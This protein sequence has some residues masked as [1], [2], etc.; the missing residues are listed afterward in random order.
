M[1]GFSKIGKVLPSPVLRNLWRQLLLCA[2][3]GL[4]AGLGAIAFF[5]LLDLGRWFFM[6][7]LIGYQPAP[8]GGESPMFTPP[9]SEL[10]RWLFLV[11]PAAGGLL[12]GVLIYSLAPEAEGHGTDAAIDAYH[13]KAGKV[14]VRVPLV[15]A[16]ASAIT[17]GSGGSGGRE[18]PIAQIGSGF[19]SML[20]TWLHLKP[21]ERRVLM[22][23][24]MGAGIGAI[25]HAPL[26]GALFSAE[27]LYR[28]LDQE[29]EVIIPS[30]VA[31]IVAYGVFATKFGWS[32]L[33]TNPGFRFDNLTELLPYFVLALVVSA[34]AIGYIKAFYGTRDLFAKIRIPNHFKPM[35]GGI[36]VGLIGYFL[37]EAIGTGYGFAQQ[38][39]YGKIGFGI[40]FAVGATKIFTTSFSIG[41]GGS[42]G[43]FGP[44]VVIG[45]ALGGGTGLLMAKVFPGMN[46]QPGAFAIVG[47]AG[48]FSGAAN[49]P[50]STIIMVSEMTGNYNLLVPAMWVC[51]LAYILC[52]RYTIYEMQLPSRF[53]AP[54]HITDMMQA[55]LQRIPVEVA[56]AGRP[57][58]KLITVREDSDLHEL[59]ELYSHS[60]Y[61]SFPIVDAGG[62]AISM[63]SGRELKT[64]ISREELSHLI[65]AGDLAHPLVKITPDN[66]LFEAVKM[67]AATGEDEICVVDSH[68]RDRVVSILGRNDVISAYHKALVSDHSGENAELLPAAGEDH[69]ESPTD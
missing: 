27:V 20:A 18:G 10:R 55:V 37:P 57:F 4:I 44:A 7:Y 38:A 25:F 40:L 62:R 16:I 59:A 14:R 43:V 46:L 15:K 52:K 33:F 61:S 31:S 63:V 3:V 67:M 17:I 9:L 2:V 29:Y 8:P 64:I 26:A 69:G 51:F 66:N 65:V 24:G 12:S 32:P 39:L 48:F 45:A 35:I 49:T 22:A 36:G 58:F 34:G 21:Y 1:K 23:A 68:D 54:V 53:D 30:V 50:I 60:Q 28:E 6:E 56:M 5:T 47:M 42:G 13:N 11:V 19:G 41:S